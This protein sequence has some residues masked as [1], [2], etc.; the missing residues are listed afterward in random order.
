MGVLRESLEVV[1][2]GKLESRIGG[3][4][5]V[6]KGLVERALGEGEEGEKWKLMEIV[7]RVCP[8]SLGREGVEMRV[9]EALKGEE[10]E[11]EKKKF[12]ESFFASYSGDLGGGFLK[13]FIEVT[14][15][16]GRNSI[17]TRLVF[18]FNDN[19][20]FLGL[21]RNRFIGLE[22]VREGFKTVL[23]LE[24]K[25]E[26]IS[27]RVLT[28]MVRVFGN[29]EGVEFGGLLGEEVELERL[30]LRGALKIEVG[31]AF[32]K[33][34]VKELMRGDAERKLSIVGLLLSVLFLLWEVVLMKRGQIKLLFQSLSTTA[35]E[36]CSKTLTTI[37]DLIPSSSASWNG[38]L[39]GTS[40]SNLGTAIFNFITSNPTNLNLIEL[41]F[42]LLSRSR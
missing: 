36:D 40:T 31:E 42:S 3:W 35:N 15:G 6:W 38:F 10:E 29:V 2:G 9:L 32:G 25:G 33:K 13:N 5:E 19:G 8:E 27:I 30:E 23:K 1:L 41:V 7:A 14:G 28:L 21:M 26:G 37:I 4:G 18:N 34:L 39:R 12:V 17:L 22:R 24:G 11:E 16:G 20:K